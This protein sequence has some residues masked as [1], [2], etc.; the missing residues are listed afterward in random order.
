MFDHRSCA[1][2]PEA[3]DQPGDHGEDRRERDAA[4][5]G[6]EQVA[7]GRALAAAQVLGEVRRGQVGARARGLDAGLAEERPGAEA[8]RRRQ[9]VEGADQAD[10]PT[11]PRPAPPW[12]WA[13]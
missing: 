5:I 9:E 2:A 11:P 13:R 1:T 7:A 8:Q 4:M 12:R 6:Q 10:R 3:D